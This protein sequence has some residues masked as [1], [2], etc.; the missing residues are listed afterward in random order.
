MLQTETRRIVRAIAITGL[1]ACCVVVVAFALTRGGSADAWK[2]GFL[3]GIAMAMAI[4]PEEFP[5]V[6]TIFLA[7]GAWRLSRSRVLTRRMP[8]VEMLGAATVLCV[9]KTGTLTQNQMT[10]RKLAIG[11]RSTDLAGLAGDLPEEVHGLLEHAI[12]ASKSDPF[13]P[14]ERALHEAGDRLMENTEHLHPGWSL[15]ARV[16]AHAGPAGRES[17]VAQREQRRRRG[18]HEGRARGHRRSL[19]SRSRTARVACS[20]GTEP[21]LAGPSRSRRGA[22]GDTG[23]AS[24]LTSITTFHSSSSACWASRTRCDRLCLARWRSARLPACAWS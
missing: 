17:R 24:C 15:G 2:Q 21:R 13:D 12:L 23:W 10:L 11:G 22:R 1:G 9:D 5:V 8:A 14:M 16:P 19:S 6:L 18:V 20:R 7:L 4:L 3:A